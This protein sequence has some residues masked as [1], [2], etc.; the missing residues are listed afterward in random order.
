MSGFYRFCILYAFI[1]GISAFALDYMGY[2]KYLF[3][4]IVVVPMIVGAIVAHSSLSKG[5]PI[6]N[7]VKLSNIGYSYI[8]IF[9][10]SV[11]ILLVHLPSAGGFRLAAV[12]AFIAAIQE[13]LVVFSSYLY[14]HIQKLGLLKRD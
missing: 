13:S 14:A 11:T 4:V 1:G 2:M 10:F 12:A 7:I 3:G 8:C 5:V 9:V 6:R